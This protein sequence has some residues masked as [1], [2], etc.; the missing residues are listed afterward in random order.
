MRSGLSRIGEPTHTI[1]A[2]DAYMEMIKDDPASQ[3]SLK[4]AQE[5]LRLFGELSGMVIPADMPNIILEFFQDLQ[6]ATAE[7]RK[8]SE[9]EIHDLWLD[10]VTQQ[11][12]YRRDWEQTYGAP[13]PDSLNELAEWVSRLLAVG[14]TMT[15]DQKRN[16]Q[17]IF[18]MIQG[19]LRGLRDRLGLPNPRTDQPRQLG[20]SG[21]WSKTKLCSDG[22]ISSGT[23][24]AI[25]RRDN[26]I[27]TR[28]R[29]GASHNEHYT[30]C[31]LKKLIA[32]AEQHGTTKSKGAARIWGKLIRD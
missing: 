29:G 4:R 31:E 30:V 28:R 15:D 19:H 6:N 16:F 2:G 13:Y 23:F 17:D 25:R 7:I 3:A 8:Q 14:N 32:A 12:S 18:P 26:S 22:E 10:F 5:Q 1:R 24:D 21:G 20:R 27:L 11:G 9:R